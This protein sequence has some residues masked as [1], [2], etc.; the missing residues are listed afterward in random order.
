MTLRKTYKD[1]YRKE[2]KTRS[3][4][5]GIMGREKGAEKTVQLNKNNKKN[6]T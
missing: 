4:E 2:K 6:N 1:L 5:I 3:E